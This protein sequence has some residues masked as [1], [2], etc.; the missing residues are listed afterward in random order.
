MLRYFDRDFVTFYIR[1]EAHVIVNFDD[2]FPCSYQS[3][4]IKV[5]MSPLHFINVRFLIIAYTDFYFFYIKFLES[6]EV[7]VCNA[8]STFASVFI[9]NDLRN[10]N[11]KFFN[12]RINIAAAIK[13][14][15]HFLEYGR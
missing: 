5:N 14:F 7:N 13:Q 3:T 6:K 15:R 9:S 11:N 12:G 10:R 4:M 8:T 2:R 1:V